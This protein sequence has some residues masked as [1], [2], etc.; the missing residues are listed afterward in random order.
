MDAAAGQA[1]LGVQ[2]ALGPQLAA[3]VAAAQAVARGGMGVTLAVE[4]EALGVQAAG[5]CAVAA[6]VNAAVA[7]AGMLAGGAA[8]A[9]ALSDEELFLYEP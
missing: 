1:L 5:S 3:A 4:P 9:S 7:P 2:S 6:T 8:S